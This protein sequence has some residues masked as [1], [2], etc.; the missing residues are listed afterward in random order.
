MDSKTRSAQDIRV[1]D[2]CVDASH[3][4]SKVSKT[5]SNAADHSKAEVLDIPAADMRYASCWI[6]L[7][8][9]F[10]DSLNLMV[11]ELI[12]LLVNLLPWACMFLKPP[13]NW[14]IPNYLFNVSVYGMVVVVNFLILLLLPWLYTAVHESSKIQSTPGKRM[15]GL[16]VVDASGKRITFGRATYKY[17]VQGL[18][19]IALSSIWMAVQAVATLFSGSDFV[20]K[21]GLKLAEWLLV[22]IAFGSIIYGGKQTFIDRMTNRYIV[23][24]VLAKI[25]PLSTTEPVHTQLAKRFAQ[26]T[27]GSVVWFG[28][29]GRSILSIFILGLLPL[30]CGFLLAFGEAWYAME[31]L[32][33]GTKSIFEK[34][35]YLTYIAGPSERSDPEYLMAGISNCYSFFY[36]NVGNIQSALLHD[37]D[38]AL[39]SYDKAMAAGINLVSLANRENW[40]VKQLGRS[41]DQYGKFSGTYFRVN[42]VKDGGFGSPALGYNLDLVAGS[43]PIPLLQRAQYYAMTGRYWEAIQDC[44]IAKRM[45]GCPE[46]SHALLAYALYKVGHFAQALNEADLSVRNA[47]QQ[48]DGCAIKAFVLADTNKR[49]LA[50]VQASHAI[51]TDLHNPYA[52]AAAAHVCNR[53][54][55]Y[56]DAQLFAERAIK[57]EP[58]AVDG[59]LE[60]GRAYVEQ[61]RYSDAVAALT[62]S[63]EIS[64]NEVDAFA[65]RASALRKLDR[66][67]DAVLDEQKANCQRLY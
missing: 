6:R 4:P 38:G 1:E 15:F 30:L 22:P 7:A 2:G 58:R 28:Q 60:L 16:K 19:I 61:G 64:P 39:R 66:E 18:C 54:K 47:P 11:I 46:Y 8:A 25:P 10:V 45:N 65:L 20:V 5:L 56:Q 13:I 42:A 27:W 24:E 52:L 48:A 36:T 43:H 29:F 57:E 26:L 53:R 12:V 31:C 63:L 9:L 14:P 23:H 49:D 34:N 55:C 50:A 51:A 32:A 67:Y 21:A 35:A 17:F 41:S 44:Q 33:T 3:L 37:Y 62:K 40:L 59:Y